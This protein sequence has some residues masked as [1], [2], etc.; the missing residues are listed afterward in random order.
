MK[1]VPPI[2]D[3]ET[4]VDSKEQ[5]IYFRAGE[6]E[7]IINLSGSL[8]DYIYRLKKSFGE[9]EVSD[10]WNGSTETTYQT[11]EYHE[12]T[13]DDISKEDL[14][15]FIIDNRNKWEVCND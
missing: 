2:H 10:N 15:Q 8:D 5:T 13:T 3:I 7:Y 12:Y 11:E 1:N 6:K 14:E 4:I 9:Y